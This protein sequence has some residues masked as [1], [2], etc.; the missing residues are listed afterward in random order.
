M[1]ELSPVGSRVVVRQ[2]QQALARHYRLNVAYVSGGLETENHKDLNLV[3][4]QTLAQHLQ[5]F[6]SDRWPP[7]LAFQRSMAGGAP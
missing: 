4:T 7:W 5:S 3:A 6:A 2:T 1:G